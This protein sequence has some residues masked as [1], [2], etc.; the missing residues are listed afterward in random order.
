MPGTSSWRRRRDRPPGS[1]PAG[2][3]TSARACA[4]ALARPPEPAARSRRPSRPRRA[5]ARAA[6]QQ[7]APVEAVAAAPGARAP[8]GRAAWSAPRGPRP[9]R[10]ASG[11]TSS[12]RAPGRLSTAAAPSAPTTANATSP[13]V[14]RRA[15][16]TPDPRA[17]H[18]EDERH[19]GEQGQLV[20]GAE[21][22]DREVLQP[23]R[24]PVDERPADRDH[25]RRLAGGDADR[26]QRRRP[27]ASAT[28]SGQG[29]GEQRRL[30]AAPHGRL[31][32]RAS[33][34][35]LPVRPGRP[36]VTGS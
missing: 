7:P 21:R 28:P 20:V 22:A 36:A 35:R 25:R 10:P 31:S 30:T 15:A 34:S 33:L 2:T 9:C 4:T 19:P 3:V 29:A 17:D 13:A 23:Q 12:G 24:R 26:D 16:R 11:A 14:R 8:S 6:E 18:H 32:R 1:A 5:I 27:A